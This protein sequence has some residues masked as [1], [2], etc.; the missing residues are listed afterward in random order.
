MIQTKPNPKWDKIKEHTQDK[1]RKNL[2]FPQL[3]VKEGDSSK[4]DGQASKKT[5]INCFILEDI[6]QAHYMAQLLASFT[7]SPAYD[8][9]GKQLPPLKSY[10][11]TRFR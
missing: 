2:Y 11:P 6:I 9:K 10:V 8:F 4:K 5:Y 1:K 7:N 3:V